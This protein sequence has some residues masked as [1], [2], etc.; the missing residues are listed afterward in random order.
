[1]SGRIYLLSDSS[2][3]TPMNESPYGSEDL[4]QRL[5]SKHPDL[6]AGEQIGP[7][8]P[9]RVM[10]LHARDGLCPARRTAPIAGLWII[11]SWIKMECRRWSR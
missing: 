1:M 6:L 7:D 10:Q 2:G 5:L 8:E 3:L 4:L 11:S 9:R